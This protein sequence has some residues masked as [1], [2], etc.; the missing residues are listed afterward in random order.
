MNMLVLRSMP[1]RGCSRMLQYV[2]VVRGCRVTSKAAGLIR[3]HGLGQAHNVRFQSTKASTTKAPGFKY[4]RRLLIYHTGTFET[5]TMGMSKL[6][7]V[8]FFIYG[9]LGVAPMLLYSPDYSSW[10]APLVVVGS[11]IPMVLTAIGTI[12]AVVNI[13]LHLPSSAC[14]SEATLQQFL[15]KMP[16]KTVIEITGMRLQPWPKTKRYFLEDLR[17]M[18]PTG[19]WNIANLERAPPVKDGKVERSWMHALSKRR[20][21]GRDGSN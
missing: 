20:V 15:R 18:K 19:F 5:A 2:S 12:S 3:S 17:T 10:L 1:L 9:T 14:R 16:G 7:P 4:P 11:A 8:F 6:I 21:A 13:T